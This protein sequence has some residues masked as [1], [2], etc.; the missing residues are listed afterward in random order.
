MS[1]VALAGCLR[2]SEQSVRLQC[3][4]YVSLLIHSNIAFVAS[5]Q[6]GLERYTQPLKPL[7]IIFAVGATVVLVERLRKEL[8]LRWSLPAEAAHGANE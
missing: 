2:T 1:L 7:V 3:L 4:A 6:A 5:V 8:A